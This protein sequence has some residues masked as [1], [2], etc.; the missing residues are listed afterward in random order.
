[1]SDVGKSRQSVQDS[2]GIRDQRAQLVVRAYG[3]L[4][5]LEM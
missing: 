2:G 4:G 3:F 5:L 1:M